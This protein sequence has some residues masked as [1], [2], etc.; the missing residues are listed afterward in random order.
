MG[1]LAGVLFD[2]S[3]PWIV[4]GSLTIMVMLK[5]TRVSPPPANIVQE[6]LGLNPLLMG[7]DYSIP[8]KNGNGEQYCMRMMAHRGGGYDFPENSLLAIQN[9]KL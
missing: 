7:K 4:W 1:V 3:I 5:L 6:V 8:E 2:F 9:V